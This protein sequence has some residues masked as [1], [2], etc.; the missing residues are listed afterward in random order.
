MK[1]WKK[2]LFLFLNFYVWSFVW[3][4]GIIYL[5]FLHQF[6]TDSYFVC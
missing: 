4:T 3:E 1:M 5:Q 2:T 6:E